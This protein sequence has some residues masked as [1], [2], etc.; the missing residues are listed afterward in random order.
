MK[1]ERDNESVPSANWNAR[2]LAPVAKLSVL[3]WIG[4]AAARLCGKHGDVSDQAG[5]AGC[6]RQ[7]V[8]DHAGKVKQAVEDA[9]LGGP[10]RE[11]LLAEN[12][13]LRQENGELWQAYVHAID[14]PEDKL[15]QFS[16]AGSAMG[17]SLTQILVL[18]AIL[19]PA[20][21]R[22]SRATLGRWVNQSARRAAGV[23]AVLDKA[24]RTV[25]FCLCLDEIFFRRK[26][27]LMGVEPHSM[28]WVIAR[29]A[30]DRSG[31]TWAKL[32]Q[33][34]PAVEDVAADGG[35]GLERGL[36]LAAAQR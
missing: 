16:S 20:A 12:A 4:N 32:L 34:W 36:G 15:R 3:T 14:C 2:G 27:V 30:P 22:P 13:L 5:K 17:L 7:T 6:S 23:L 8:Y 28:A 10:S 24:C 21:R 31:E 35:T 9:L 25:V 1:G 33:A 19:L 29:R 18:L 11:Q 26:P